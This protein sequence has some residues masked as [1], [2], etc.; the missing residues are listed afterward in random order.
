MVE[1]KSTGLVTPLVFDDCECDIPTGAGGTGGTGA[2]GAPG[3][4]GAGGTG[5]T[6]GVGGTGGTGPAGGATADDITYDNGYAT[7]GDALDALLYVSPSVSLSGGSS[8]ETGSMVVDVSLSWTCNKTMVTRDLSAPVP[9]E[10]RARGSGQNGSYNHTGSNLV[11]NTSY[12]ITVNDGTNSANNSTTV[13]F[14]NQRYYG[15]SADEGPLLN[16]EILALSKEFASSVANTHTYN[17]SGS[18]YIW[19]CYPA[20]LGTATFYVGGLEVT[21]DLTIQDVTNDSSCLESFNCY[22]SQEIQTGSD[23]EV[24]V[25]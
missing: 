21:F 25:S 13:A 7:V 19:I 14:Y 9:V 22:R 11:A 1:Y 18:K 20:S 16:S 12:T 15:V 24:V 23:I 6:G 3:G 8:N 2:T 4:T 5:G 17:C 10:D